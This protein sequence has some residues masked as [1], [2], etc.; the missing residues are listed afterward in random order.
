MAMQVGIAKL[1][2]DDVLDLWSH[3]AE[4]CFDSGGIILVNRLVEAMIILPVQ[5]LPM[6]LIGVAVSVHN[7]NGRAFVRWFDNDVGVFGVG[8]N[9]GSVC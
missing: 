6:C 1:F 4:D 7:D 8:K 3:L 2:V 5:L 9:E